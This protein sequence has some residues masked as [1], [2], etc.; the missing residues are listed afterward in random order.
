MATDAA[1]L[2]SRA[3]DRSLMHLGLQMSQAARAIPVWAT[4]AALGRYGV[5][6]LV[7]RC[8]DL[9]A[10]FA[11]RLDDAGASILA[12]VVLNQ[13]LA[14]FG[15]DDRTDAVIE[16]VARS[17][18]AWMGGTTWQGRR[19]MRISVS[20]TATDEAAV[21]EAVDAVLTAWLEL[22]RGPVPN[23]LVE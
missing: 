19:A 11:A 13:V 17:G 9:A 1:Y 8:C 5:A 16:A 7:D 10:R 14:S 2:G 18:R 23:N 6:E 3:G 20:D 4:L 15:T 12:P 22:T 21:D